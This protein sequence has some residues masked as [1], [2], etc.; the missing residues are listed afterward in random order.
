MLVGRETELGALE[1]WLASTGPSLLEIE[2]EPGIG[3]TA[4]WEEGVR[5]AREAGA[6]VLV[7]RPVEIE[8]AVSY[9]ALAALV[10]PA[11][12]LADGAVPG[13]RRR[14]LEGALRLRDL[15]SSLD[16][17]AVALGATSVIRAAAHRR[18]V[19]VA[20]EDV[21]WLDASSRVAL[22]SRPRR[23]QHVDLAEAR[24][25]APMGDGVDL[26]RLPLP[27]EE[28]AAEHVAL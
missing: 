8:T 12:A 20:L 4:L 6:L 10:E 3:K 16:E 15:P 1:R 25:R 22:T 19:V 23:V 7:S 13:P 28:G 9:G 21:Q 26:S 18:P 24:R 5:R 14:A 27:V 2:G 17:T 11:L